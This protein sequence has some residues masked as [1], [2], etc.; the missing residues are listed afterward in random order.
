MNEKELEAKAIEYAII[1][2]GV[3]K[4]PI[5]GTKRYSEVQIS[6]DDFINGYKQCLIDKKVNEMLQTL[7]DIKDYLGSDKRK[8]VEILIKEATEIK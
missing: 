4:M 8:E 7:N 6:K 1:E 2:W 3:D 5:K